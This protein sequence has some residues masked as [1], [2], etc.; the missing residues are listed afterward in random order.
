MISV[1]KIK[2]GFVLNEKDIISFYLLKD[3]YMRYTFFKVK[4]I[5]QRHTNIDT[6]KRREKSKTGVWPTQ[7]K[8]KEF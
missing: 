7:E 3:M 5:Q 4:T 2:R 1:N 8:I 6:R